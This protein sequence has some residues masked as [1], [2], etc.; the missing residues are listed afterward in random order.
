MR[1][2]ITPGVIGIPGS[3]DIPADEFA[4]LRSA[5]RDLIYAL[6]IEETFDLLLENYAEFESDL[7]RLSLRTA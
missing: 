5:Q 1:Y 7:L 2:A 3:I 6:N 4:K